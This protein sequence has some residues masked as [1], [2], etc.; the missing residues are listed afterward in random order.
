MTLTDFSTREITVIQELANSKTVKEIA[1]F[2]GKRPKTIETLRE[3]IY[4]KMKW[5]KH[6]CRIALLTA[7]AFTHGLCAQPGS[8]L[9]NALSAPKPAI[10]NTDY[11]VV[12]A[13]DSPG[14]ESD[15]STELK[16][17]TTNGII[18]L[19]WD[20]VPGADYYK[21]YWGTNHNS[22]QWSASLPGTA[23]NVYIRPQP[24]ETNYQWLYA[25]GGPTL[26]DIRDL[27]GSPFL[28]WTN[29]TGGL[30]PA[31]SG[32]QPLQFTR[33]RM[34]GWLTNSP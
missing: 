29:V 33:I 7:W 20:V 5:P 12:T 17:V 21:L 2:L 6:K 22:Y 4:R 13:V 3:N 19:A 30:T 16:V 9:A 8:R 18:G 1:L 11:F 31:P 10:T 34:S 23:L 27:S 28:V 26:A 15:Y 32:L 14:G 24:A 25:Q